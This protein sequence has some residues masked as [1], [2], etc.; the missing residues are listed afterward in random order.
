[1]AGGP[2]FMTGD[3]MAYPFWLVFN[4]DGTMRLVRRPPTLDRHERG[5]S[6]SATLPM[7]LWDT[8]MLNATITLAEGEPVASF[9]LD[10]VAAAGALRSALGVDVHVVEAP[11]DPE[12]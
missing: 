1:V 10:V 7:S 11:R 5:M 9:N 3:N 2:S 12:P 4:R 6:V 8:P